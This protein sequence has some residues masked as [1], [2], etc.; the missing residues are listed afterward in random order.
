MASPS[1]EARSINPRE[2]GH[3]NLHISDRIAK[4]D[5]SLGPFSSIKYN[6]KPAQGS[7]ERSSTLTSTAADTYALT[8]QDNDGDKT[9]DVFVFTGQ[10]QVAKKQYV[11]LFDP[12]SQ[13]ATLEPLSSTYTFNL[14]KKNRANVSTTHPKIYPRK[15]KDEAVPPPPE[16]DNL[17]DEAAKDDD[18]SRDPEADNPFDFRHFLGKD[19]DKRGDE[20]P[21]LLPNSPDSRAGTG[22][23]A[24]TPLM[25]ARKPAAAVTSKPK[26]SQAATKPRKRKSPEAE[27]FMTKKPPARKA[28][29]TPTVRVERRASTHPTTKTTVPAKPGRKTKATAQAHSKFKSAEIVQSSDES[30]EDAEGEAVSSP[31]A[32]RQRSP[33]PTSQQYLDHDDDDE[34]EEEEED[35]GGFGGGSFFEIE[36]PDERPSKPKHNALKSLGLGQNLGIGYLKSPSNGP[37]SLVSAANS[38]EGS[39]NP[40]FTPRKPGRHGDVDDEILDFGN[41]GGGRRNDSDEDEDEEDGG[42]GRNADEAVDDRDVEPMSLGSPAQL[43]DKSLLSQQVEDDDDDPFARELMKEFAG[44]DSSEESEEE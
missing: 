3:F 10:K 30:D 31:P 7:S 38:V 22:S 14:A 15:P 25:V 28:Q 23:A 41:M 24:N 36:D 17:F 44:G 43:Q 18:I 34:D 13:R 42:Y 37:M 12:A 19:K 1:V 35:K 9:G 11:L 16:S 21:F 33:E 6:H 2:K 27:P 20:S 29:P 4:G 26:P 40:R 8:L 39:P 5:G 32:P